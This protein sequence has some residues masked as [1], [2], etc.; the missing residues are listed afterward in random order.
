MQQL[1]PWQIVLF[2]AAIGALSFGMW[3]I[4]SRPSP[5]ASLA[6]SMTFVDAETGKLFVFP[7]GGGKAVMPPERHPDTKKISLVPVFQN[8]QGDWLVPDRYTQVLKILEVENNV[9]D[10]ETLQVQVQEGRPRRVNR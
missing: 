9:I 5:A 3:R 1:K 10:P 2:V 8:D 4:A 6:N 7:V